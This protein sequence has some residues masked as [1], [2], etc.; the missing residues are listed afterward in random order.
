MKI[1]ILI[2]VYNDFESASKLI[3]EINSKITNLIH[4]FS[5]ILVNDASTEKVEIEVSIKFLFK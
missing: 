5:I 2:P 4:E 1:K 3:E